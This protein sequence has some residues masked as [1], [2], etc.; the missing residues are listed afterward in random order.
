[1]GQDKALLPFGDRPLAVWMA[2]LVQAVCEDVSLVGSAGKYSGLGFPVIEDVFPG[3]GPLAGIYAALAHS[4]ARFNLIVGCDMPYL[5]KEFLRWLLGV[6]QSGK[7]D[8]VIPASEAHGYEPLCA[9]YTTAC[10]AAMEEALRS[11]ERKI[12]GFFERARVRVL[13]QQEWK[14]YDPGGRLFRNLN[15]WEEYEQ[16]RAELLTGARSSHR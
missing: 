9:V 11:G 7:E 6:A 10:R 5:S 8:L 4:E 16:A 1:M 12:S 13:T 3:Q 14:L 15:T 2:E